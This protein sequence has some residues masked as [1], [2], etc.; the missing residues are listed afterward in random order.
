MLVTLWSPK[1]GSGTSVV[2]ALLAAVHAAAGERVLLV[3]VAGGLTDVLGV[4]PSPATGVRDFCLAEEA[5]PD[6]LTRLRVDVAERVALLP[7][8]GGPDPGPERAAL[9]A[10]VVGGGEELVV[11]DAGSADDELG[12]AFLRAATLRFMVVRPCYLA[13]RAAQRRSE[14]TDGVVVVTEPGRALSTADVA[15][16]AGVPVVAELPW[17]PAT[18]RL[19]D[20]GLL[21]ARP[22]RRAAR[23]LRGVLDR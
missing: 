16:A 12:R 17:D 4:G 6:A 5:P 7:S 10:A 22:P 14:P 11:I 9:V 13:L 20:A 21:L 18:A 19:V 8:G 23:R 1:G 3:D 15:A 2:C